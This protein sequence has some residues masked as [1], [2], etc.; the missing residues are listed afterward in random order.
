MPDSLRTTIGQFST[1]GGKVQARA[2]NVRAV[3]PAA[4]LPGA[5]R[6]SL[7]VLV[8]VSG[9]GGG[10]AA[11]YRQLL[12]AAQTAFYEA[13]GTVSAA[14]VRAAR[15]AH[16]VLVRANEGL[17]EANWRAGIS[18]VALQGQ[19]LTIAQAGPALALVS[20]PKTVEQFP[21]EAEA[22]SP[23]IGGGERPRVDLFRTTVEPGSMLL[24]AQSNWL[25]LVTPQA[26]A[27]AAA[28]E[29]VGLATD[30]LSQLAGSGELSALL[31]SFEA[32]PI[33][34]VKGEAAAA[35]AAVAP[36]A[37]REMPVGSA[38]EKA[39]IG[40]AAYVESVASE[41]EEFEDEEPQRRSPW[42]LLLAL[43]IIPA[44]IG[45]LVFG[46][47]WLYRQRV[48][49]QFEQTMQG[50]TTALNQVETSP[51]DATAG[52]RLTA[53]YD[54][55]E[56]A[57]LLRP[58]DPRLVELDKRYQEYVDRLYHV[59]PLYGIVPLW[60]FQ[61]NDRDLKRVQASG[62]SL[63][64]LDAKRNEVYRFILSQLKDS[65]TPAEPPVVIS[66]TQQLGSVIVSDLQDITWADA[67]NGQRSQLLTLDTAKNLFGYDV[68]LGSDAVTLAAS[69]NLG[70]PQLIASYIG[71][72]YIVDTT[73]GQIWR[74]QPSANG[75]DTPPEPYFADGR[76]LDMTGIQGIAIDGNVWLLFA[77]GRLLKFLA[78]QQ[79]PFELKGLP[80]PLSAPVAVVA[81]L[82]DD[83]LY[84][85]DGGN[86]RI[87]EFNKEGEFQRQFR[88]RE[89]DDLQT[90]RSFVLD[91]AAGAFYILTADK[92]YKVDVPQSGVP[93]PTPTQ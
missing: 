49:A 27:A 64:V 55:L 2:T 71:K 52:Q 24:L 81:A 3:E 61:G 32:P 36:S 93:E 85:A 80:S 87:V 65:V 44:I 30:Y 74:Y 26:L 50:A 37:G 8:E 92:L 33:P 21:G 86:G 40:S 51:D 59:T 15:S 41:E 46:M 63:Y 23:S 48:E 42:P 47:W 25:D 7:Y 84:I 17:P 20:H 31:V 72:L 88:A 35:V 89:G 90:M 62:D 75:Y 45:V 29:S 6:G 54:F 9:T 53:V 18:L 14:L 28:A 82:E 43:V 83:R 78:G 76:T 91:E 10:H 57:R 12:S 5:E 1:S 11:L 68:S 34:E 39:A 16:S 58:D 79:Q 66:K 73:A 13:S 56:K 69:S 19:E 60:D 4:N 70:L 38:S 77:D 22:W 67:A